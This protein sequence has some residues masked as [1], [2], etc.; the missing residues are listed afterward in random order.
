MEI[1]RARDLVAS[2]ALDRAEV[3]YGPHAGLALGTA[4]IIDGVEFPLFD[5]AADR[6]AV[7]K[8]LVYVLSHECDLDPANERFL[9]DSALVCPI[10]ALE[11]FVAEATS[12]GLE[13][14]LVGGFLGHL[15]VRN[16]SRATYMPPIADQLPSGGFMYFNRIVSTSVKRLEAGSRVCALTAYGLTTVDMALENHL[17]RPKADP[18]PLQ[19]ATIRTGSSKRG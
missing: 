13:D 5:L 15:A 1:E 17:R 16:V 10:V 11:A 18:L 2:K 14:H 12:A 8:G 7:L 9:N 19:R 6:F 3:F 4:L